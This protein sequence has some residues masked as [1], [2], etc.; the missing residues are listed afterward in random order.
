MDV[1]AKKVQDAMF[2]T[3]ASEARPMGVTSLTAVC[4]GVD[5]PSVPPILERSGFR[6]SA[7][8]TIFSWN[9]TN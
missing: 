8:G 2:A 3:L 9:T 6:R 5:R 1:D 4:S 7:D